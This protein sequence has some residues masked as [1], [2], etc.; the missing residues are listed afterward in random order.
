MICKL[1]DSLPLGPLVKSLHYSEI[2][3]SQF[4]FSLSVLNL[5]VL[6]LSVLNI[7]PGSFLLV[8]T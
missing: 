7:L 2:F 4:C 3:G 1:L 5:S 8:Y 6:S